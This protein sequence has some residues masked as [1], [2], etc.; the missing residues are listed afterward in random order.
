[1][2]VAVVFDTPYE[3]WT[4]EQ[5]AV[6]MAKDL[7]NW[8]KAEPD[9]EYQ[10]AQALQKNGH[11]VLLIGIHDDLRDMSARLADWKPDLVFNATEA[12]LDNIS[13]DYLVPALLEAEGYRY[14]GAPPLAL[15]VTRNK[16]MAK[17]VLAYH[18]VNVPA[19][20]SYRVGEK[21]G[22]EGEMR[23]PL[24]V[25]PLST[26]ASEGIAQASIVHDLAALRERV[27]FIHDRFAQAALA[28]EYIEGREIYA[29]MLGN[30]D[31]VEILPIV[32][33]VFDAAGSRPE[34]R[35]ATQSAKWTWPT[36][37]AEASRTCSRAGCRRSQRNG[38]PRSATHRT[39]H[40]GYATTHASTSASPPTTRSGSSRP[41]PIRSSAMATIRQR[42]PT[43][44]DSTTT[45]SSSGSST[46]P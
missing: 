9:M 32:E 25:K 29:T 15:L 44:S 38:S 37:S 41:T 5:H 36:A 21:P 16:A 33:M 14:T 17:K 6:Q 10:V 20:K 35:I 43:S 34:D 26:D 13:L 28:E 8:K 7:A 24:I 46:K 12:F 11:D 39:A 18:G 3:G 40:S 2:R 31:K 27:T 4:P 23:F 22:D 42:P 19:F 30:G 1:M 45:R